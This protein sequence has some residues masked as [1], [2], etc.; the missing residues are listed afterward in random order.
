MSSWEDSDMSTNDQVILNQMLEK[1]QQELSVSLSESEFFELFACEQILKDH[2][3]SWEEIESGIVGDGGDGGID[4]FYLF[5]N[6][7]I[8]SLA[9]AQLGTRCFR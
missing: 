2:D 6:D 8:I 1:R 5:V 9:V 3:L 4:G 7:E